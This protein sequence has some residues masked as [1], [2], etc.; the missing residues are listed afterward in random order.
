MFTMVA[1]VVDIGS[2]R[3]TCTNSVKGLKLGMEDSIEKSVTRPLIMV[4]SSP[5]APVTIGKNSLPLPRT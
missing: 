2:L 4:Q 5:Y 3:V 1:A